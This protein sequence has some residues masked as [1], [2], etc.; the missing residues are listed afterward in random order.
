MMHLLAQQFRLDRLVQSPA[1]A[2]AFV[3]SLALFGM[4]YLFNGILAEF[5]PG[6]WWGL[7]YGI[8]SS[9]LM[10]GAGLYAVRR[11]L[12][13]RDVG[14]STTWVQFHVYAGTLAGLLVLMH[15]DFRLPYGLFDWLLWLLS[16]W[17]TASGILGVALQRWI[18]RILASGLS[19]EA[20]Y[21]RIPELV[22]Q[23]RMRAEK[24]A[25]TCTQPVRDFY[26]ADIAPVLIAPEPRLI[27]Y[28]DV[29]GGIQSRIRQFDFLRNV[30]AAGEKEKLDQLRGL[31]KTKLELDAHFSL[32]RPLRWWLLTH[33]PLSLLLLLMIALHIWAVWYY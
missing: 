29:T 20:V 33:V 7:T 9:L 18:P 31:F 1:W 17:V 22:E 32:Q 26:R 24:L 3:V 10:A 25:E 27:Y 4:M 11:R 5:N 2:G 12:L 6:N 13:K 23:I 28:I 15:T 19:V 14:N 16:L 30:L 8:A 21:E